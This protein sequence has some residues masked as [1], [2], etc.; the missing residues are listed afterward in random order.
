[1]TAG[2]RKMNVNLDKT[3]FIIWEHIIGV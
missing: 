1:V 3:D 2:S